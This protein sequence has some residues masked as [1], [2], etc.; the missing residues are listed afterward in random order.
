MDK[1]CALWIFNTRIKGDVTPC[2]L[3]IYRRST[4]M[5]MNFYQ[6]RRSHNL[7]DS[8][9]HIFR[10]DNLKLTMHKNFFLSW[11]SSPT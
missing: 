5:L 1:V 7:E 6:T 2:S 10:R 3:E 4:E 11:T 8:T 9:L